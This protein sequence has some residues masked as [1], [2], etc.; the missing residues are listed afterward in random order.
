MVE[1]L[2]RH[3]YHRTDL[4]TSVG[5]LAVRGGVFDV[6]PPGHDEP[7]RLDLFGDTIDS[8]R[9]FDAVS[10][11]SSGQL[12]RATVLPLDLFPRGDDEARLLGERLAE[13][14][15]DQLGL[16]A[17]Q[18][19]AGLEEGAT[20]PGWENLLPLLTRHPRSLVD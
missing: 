2:V 15:G 18:R 19:L 10:Q 13:L 16:E 8:I 20:F 11:R 9:T 5:E 4:V 3:G 14:V 7:L 17:G 6:F 1:H 12:E